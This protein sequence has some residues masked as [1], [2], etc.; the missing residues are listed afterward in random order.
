MKTIKNSLYTIL[1]SAFVFLCAPSDSMARPNFVGLVPNGATARC[2]TC[3]VNSTGGSPWNDFGNQLRQNLKNGSPDWSAVY[4]LDA[5]NDGQTNGEE[6]GDPCG[7]WTSGPA[8]RTS[9]I[10]N[11]GQSS[12]KSND[13]KTPSCTSADAGVADSGAVDAAV[14]DSGSADAAASPDGG[15]VADTGTGTPDAGVT[16]DSSTK[17]DSGGTG[18]NTDD[19]GGCSVAGQKSSG[20]GAPLMIVIAGLAFALIRRRR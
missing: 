19:D 18:G 4:N 11:P 5:D 2:Q 14:A 7:T 17:A 20:S 3:H 10:S 15:V 8:P 12:S 13:P 16:V 1:F 6:L 9:E